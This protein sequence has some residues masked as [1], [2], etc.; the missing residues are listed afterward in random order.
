MT[1]IEKLAEIEEAKP[2]ELIEEMLHIA[3]MKEEYLLE[4]LLGGLFEAMFGDSDDDEECNGDCEN[5][6]EMPQELKNLFD[7]IFG[8][9]K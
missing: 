7:K 5:C 4:G 8:G 1:I 2:T 3:Y 9:S 6:Q